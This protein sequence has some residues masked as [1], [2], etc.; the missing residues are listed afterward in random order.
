MVSGMKRSDARRICPECMDVL[1]SAVFILLSQ[2]TDLGSVPRAL[3]RAFK[4]DVSVS[5]EE[6]QVEVG[7]VIHACYDGVPLCMSEAKRRIEEWV[8]SKIAEAGFVGVPL[9]YYYCYLGDT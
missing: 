1:L 7:G 8:D 4:L 6:N 9:S 5:C 2:E 3:E